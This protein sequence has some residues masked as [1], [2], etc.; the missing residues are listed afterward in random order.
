MG[1]VWCP[2]LPP[3]TGGVSLSLSCRS[4]NRTPLERASSCAALANLP[5]SEPFQAC[6]ILP[7]P[8][9]DAPLP[10]FP[11]EL[12]P[13]SASEARPVLGGPLC[14]LCCP[15]CL[16]SPLTLRLCSQK[17]QTP[18]RGPVQE[19]G[20]GPPSGSGV[21]GSGCRKKHPP[22]LT[23]FLSDSPQAWRGAPLT[24][25]MHSL[26]LSQELRPLS[27][28]TSSWGSSL[29]RGQPPKS[30][31][32]LRLYLQEVPVAQWGAV[33]ED[34]VSLVLATEIQL[35][36]TCIQQLKVWMR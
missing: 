22:Q 32:I 6:Q 26:Q 1:G 3:S 27:A 19:D 11:Q 14:G 7:V 23:C 18:Q 36:G 17:L 30:P 5:S 20:A 25:R 31:L 15:L 4:C 21:I 13:L 9:Q 33:Q 10:L 2:L 12:S 29:G 28:S 34:G 35:Q 8:S 16:H 24:P